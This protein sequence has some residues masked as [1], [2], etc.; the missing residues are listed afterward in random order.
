MRPVLPSAVVNWFP[1]IV[2]VVS[3]IR[4][5][6]SQLNVPAYVPDRSICVDWVA[7]VVCCGG[8]SWVYATALYEI[9]KAIKSNSEPAILVL[10]DSPPMLVSG[11]I[12]TDAPEKLFIKGFNKQAGTI[13]LV[14]LAGTNLN[15]R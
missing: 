5:I 14:P 13:D 15:G 4:P 8:G 7:G 3:P 12:Q 9:T 2:S 1:V 6:D 10:I 11:A